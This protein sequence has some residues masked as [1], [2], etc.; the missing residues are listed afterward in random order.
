VYPNPVIDKLI[1]TIPELSIKNMALD[2]YNN[3][4]VLVE[5]QILTENTNEIYVAN[6][7]SGMYHY[8]IRKTN[9]IITKGKIVKI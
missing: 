8:V 2:L 4:G 5:R 7:P 9:Q 3:L 6:F 1:V